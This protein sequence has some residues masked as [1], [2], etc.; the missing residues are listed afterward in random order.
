MPEHFIFC[1][2]KY[3]VEKK[4][5][6]REK[7]LTHDVVMLVTQPIHIYNTGRNLTTDNW[8]TSI[9]LAESLLEKRITL[10]G[11]LK[12]NRTQ[13][14]FEFLPNNRRAIHSVLGFGKTGKIISYV[15]KK[16]KFVVLFS[17]FHDG[18]SVIDNEDNNKPDEIQ[19]Y[20]ITKGDVDTPDK[21]CATYS[22]QR[23]TRVGPWSFFIRC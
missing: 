18:K 15:Q 9:P 16:N 21:L 6:E 8:Y 20:N 17:S 13:I 5:N 7:N 4:C 14:S 19:F 1:L 22:T 3:I 11:T 23:A 2:L 12:K 10:V